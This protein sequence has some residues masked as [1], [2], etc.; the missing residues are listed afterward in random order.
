MEI[1]F[2]LDWLVP[3]NIQ[4]E[5]LLLKVKNH[6]YS[7]DEPV[8]N[9][10][11]RLLFFGLMLLSIASCQFNSR[12]ENFWFFRFGI[13]N[14]RI[15]FLIHIILNLAF[16]ILLFLLLIVFP[17]IFWFWIFRL[18][19]F[20]VSINSADVLRI[21][22]KSLL[23]FRFFFLNLIRLSFFRIILFLMNT[24]VLN[25]LWNTV[26]HRLLTNSSFWIKLWSCILRRLHWS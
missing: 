6:W 10:L 7:L 1:E 17:S 24:H 14:L 16:L 13:L 5:M 18:L 3:C 21:C 26:F 23:F 9:T 2:S 11:I 19:F 25:I 15:L 22:V 8:V 4:I 20:Y 12:S